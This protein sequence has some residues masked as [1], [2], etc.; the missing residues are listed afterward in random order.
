MISKFEIL[1]N[2][3]CERTLAMQEL[4]HFTHLLVVGIGITTHLIW[5]AVV[6]ALTVTGVA[7]FG[8]AARNHNNWSWTT[9]P[10]YWG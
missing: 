1:S 6:I 8:T 9:T 3:V 10:D 4:F 5:I 7:L 2:R